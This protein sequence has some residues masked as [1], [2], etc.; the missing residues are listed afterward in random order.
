MREIIKMVNKKEKT[1]KKYCKNR[2]AGIGLLDIYNKIILKQK[3]KTYHKNKQMNRPKK[4]NTF[5][6]EDVK[7]YKEGEYT[8]VCTNKIMN[9]QHL[10]EKRKKEF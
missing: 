3:E 8:N 7:I 1:D 6:K 4:R 5:T 10:S 9:C 2:P